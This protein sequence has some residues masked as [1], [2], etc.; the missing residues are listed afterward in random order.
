MTTVRPI[1]VASSFFVASM[2]S[3]RL[4]INGRRINNR[5]AVA[6]QSVIKI[7]GDDVENIQPRAIGREG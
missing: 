1:L 2:F 4:T 7:I 3:P 5:V 6:T